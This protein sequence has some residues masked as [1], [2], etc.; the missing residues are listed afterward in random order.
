MNEI[1]N[2]KSEREF[3]EKYI[4]SKSIK[5]RLN[6]MFAKQSNVKRKH[7]IILM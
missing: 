4:L 2:N 3:A 7:S 6:S 1:I 5:L